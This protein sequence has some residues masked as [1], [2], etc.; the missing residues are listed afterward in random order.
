M[1][2]DRLGDVRR[3]FLDGR[4]RPTPLWPTWFGHSLGRWEGKTLVIET[5]ALTKESILN[6]GG[7]PHS[8]DM[9]LVERL[10][11]STRDG[12]QWLNDEIT[13]TDATMYE[14]PIK[15]TQRFRRVDG[16][17]MSEG[18]VL[19]LLDQWR[20]DLE[21]RNQTLAEGPQ[22]APAKE[23]SHDASSADAGT[24][25]LSAA[26][27]SR[28]CPPP[29]AGSAP[30]DLSGVWMPTALGPD[31]NRNRTW[32]AKPPFVPAVQ[33][34]YDAYR[35]RA[36]ANPEEYDN[37]RSCLP[38]IMPR[39]MLLVAQYPLEIV[40]TRGP[41]DDDLRAAQRRAAHLPRRAIA[42]DG[43]F[44]PRGWATPWVTGKARR[45][46]S[47]TTSVRDGT[48]DQ[49]HGPNMTLTERLRLITDKD[50]KTMLEDEITVDDPATYSEPFKVRN[51]FRQRA[52]V[53]IGEY[54]CSEDLWQQ[55]L[56]GN[57]SK[58]P[59]RNN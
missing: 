16:A 6:D 5:L 39:P 17:Q 58:I 13:I 47:R 9:R 45:W 23:R 12:T 19:C 53:E 50:G 14:A 43:A 46:S 40:Q 49:P 36:D 8:E 29:A 52:G 3:I 48:I 51:F 44:G 18:S 32:P 31:G 7:L 24:G 34:A 2:F 10:S 26:R 55:N 25:R 11:L 59:W 33:A 15:V 20:Q 38:Y 56:S 22:P 35:V 37:A 28:R 42:A 1:V 30:V 27:L 54:F 21:R 41:R 57:T 4:A